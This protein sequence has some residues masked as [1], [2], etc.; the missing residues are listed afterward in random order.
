MSIL[1]ERGV[2][3]D[4][5][6]RFGVSPLH[7]AAQEGNPEI[8]DMLLEHGSSPGVQTMVNLSYEC[9]FSQASN[10]C[11]RVFEA[12]TLPLFNGTEVLSSASD[13]ARLFE[14][15]VISLPVFPLRTNLKLHNI[16]TPKIV[17]KDFDLSKASGPDCIPK[18]VL[19]NYDPE[20]SYILAELFN[21]YLKE[22]FF[23]NCWKASVVVL[24]FKN[25]GEGYS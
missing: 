6:T 20:L 1:L 22:S 2:Q 11:K 10:R 5:T 24:L 9:Y 19:K 14:N 3:A 7:L 23:P 13:K 4:T 21:M 17:K 18:V 16:S 8:V 25:I 15:F 12:D